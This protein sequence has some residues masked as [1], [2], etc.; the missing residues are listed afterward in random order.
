[1]SDHFLQTLPLWWET[2]SWVNSLGAFPHNPKD[3]F[4][5]HDNRSADAVRAR[6]WK[7]WWV[8]LTWVIWKHRNG[9]VFH[10]H[11][12][13]GSKV[14]DDAI[15]LIWSWLKNMEKGFTV[16]FSSWSSQL[17]AAF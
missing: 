15:F 11:H 9:V 8:V 4:L 16:P 14:M 5:Q 3:H 13:D 1:M 10:N 17:K 6:R 7:S 12:F 2:Q